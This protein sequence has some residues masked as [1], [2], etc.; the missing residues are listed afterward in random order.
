MVEQGKI[1]LLFDGSTSWRLRVDYDRVAE[2]CSQPGRVGWA[3]ARRHP[4]I[5]G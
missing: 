2:H 1:A 5:P 3:P 4:P